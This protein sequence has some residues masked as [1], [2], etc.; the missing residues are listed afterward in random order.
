M[1]N[2]ETREQNWLETH[3]RL[4]GLT[5]AG[6][7][8]D[9]SRRL[10]TGLLENLRRSGVPAPRTISTPYVNTIPPEAE[11][12]MPGDRTMEQRIKSLIRWNAM[13]MV[14]NANRKHNGL[15]GHISTYASSATLYE[16]GFNHFFRGRC[17]EHPADS[18]YFQGHA[19]P[20]VYARAFLEGRL[21]ESQLQHFRQELAEG[22][23]LSSYPHPY[24][25]PDFWQFPTVSMGLGPIMSIY[26]ARF[27]RYL[28]A[29]GFLKS[30]EPK[31]WC[32]VGDGESDEPE[33]LGSLTLASREGLDNLVWVVNCNLQRLDGPVRG[34]G[35]IIQEL[36]AAFRGAGW[37][38]IKV[39]WGSNWDPLL[40][41]DSTGLLIK[42]MEEAV[43]GDYQKYSVE[44]GSYTRKHFFG[45]Y[46]ELLTL[47]NHLTDDE[48][49][50]LLRGGHDPRKVHAAYRA[51]ME[52][53]GQPTV[54]LA[55]TIKGYGLGEAGEGRNITH[56]QKKLNEKELREFR[57]RFAV[58]IQDE[59]I[60]EA[61]FYRPP[62]GSPEAIY[63]HDR[64]RELGGFVP[65]RRVLAE[66][67]PV[68]GIDTLAEFLK[69]SGKLEVST[70][71]AFVRLLSVLL[72]H[73]GIGRHIV[74]IIPDEARTFGMDALF[75]EVGIYAHRGQLYEPVDSKS[76]LYYHETKDGQI[77]EEGITEAGS[78]SSFIAAGTAYA[79]HG[80]NMIPFYIYYSM[81]GFQRVGDL[82]WLAGDIKARGFLLGATSGRTSLNGEGLQHQD[83]HSLL[84]AS[85]IPTLLAYDPA[86]A[87]EVALIVA[88]GLKRMY[89]DGEDLFYYLALYNDN[90]LMP[91][92]PE[93]VE[94]GVLDG[95][96]RFQAG[97]PG[98]P[99]KAHLLG[100]GPII[101]E[102]LRARTILAERYGVSADVWSGTSYKR[103]RNEAVQCERWNRLHP[104]EPA[105]IPLV[106][107][108]LTGEEGVFV[109]VSDNIRAVPD[110]IAPWVPGGLVT[111]GTD[112]FGRSDTRP[113]LRR[114]FEVDAESTVIA[115][116]HELARRGAIEPKVVAGAVSDL[117]VDPEKPFAQLR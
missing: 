107:Q 99:H 102:A 11:P 59:E 42:R 10:L 53:Q 3:A 101:N 95:L 114:F 34:N 2:Q 15:G 86:F 41:A 79:T 40:A 45:K 116:L 60:A 94:Q 80:V 26:Q 81:F 111:L 19:S 84:A 72:R 91:P 24:L 105:R 88:D 9:R 47:V 106:R 5:L 89:Q 73:R 14:V 44:P 6:H 110:L 49:R 17:D 1:S 77:L 4:L 30:P 67:L 109:A 69:G 104:T 52:H 57:S 70:T 48:I 55:K 50:K 97:P 37:N 43:D 64:R 82:M 63:L 25:M 66:P 61:P 16:V 98:L 13:A 46:P 100:S 18:V 85:T 22:G 65:E 68:P 56:Q 32:F 90:Y 36:E 58:P 7:D 28:K 83:G 93:G 31:V 78:M 112:G 62:E 71:M 87:F 103:L 35:K 12:P 8:G 39:I 74:P 108:K 27:N 115:T 117:G 21:Q 75:R 113:R 23:G 51:A 20:G 33:T 54:I 76:L 29:R 96:Y 38:V 92:M